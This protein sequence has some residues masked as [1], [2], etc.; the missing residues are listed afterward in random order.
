MFVF[1]PETAVGEVEAVVL[2]LCCHH[3]CDWVTYTGK[4]FLTDLGLSA[5]D[6]HLICSMT[7]WATCATRTFLN[8]LAERGTEKDEENETVKGAA[9]DDK[10]TSKGEKD[11]GENGEPDPKKAKVDNSVNKVTDTG[12]EE[13]ETAKDTNIEELTSKMKQSSSRSVGEHE[14]LVDDNDYYHP[15]YGSL[16]PEQREEVGYEC[17]KLIDTGR[18][19]YI[20]AH[21]FNVRLVKYTTSELSLEN[22]ALL[23]TRKI[24]Q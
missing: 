11:G 19:K 4:Q 15:R 12:S 8:K 10:T 2:A 14:N 21:G 24:K 3:R 17:K 9:N 22:V 1:L 20:E 16:T 13:S 23:A 6:F 18:M 7:S 5:K